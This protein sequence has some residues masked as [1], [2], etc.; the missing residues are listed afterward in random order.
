MGDQRKIIG[1]VWIRTTH[2]YSL[3]IDRQPGSEEYIHVGKVLMQQV[4]DMPEYKD[5]SIT[6]Q[7]EKVNKLQ[8]ILMLAVGFKPPQGRRASPQIRMSCT[9]A[10]RRGVM[11]LVKPQPAPKEEEKREM[12]AA[13]RADIPNLI[14][15]DKE[16]FA[17]EVGTEF[18]KGM[19]LSGVTIYLVNGEFAG[20]VYLR[21]R[22][23]QSIGTSPKHQRQGIA[24]KLMIHALAK[25]GGPSRGPIT[26]HVNKE[27]QGALGWYTSIGFTIGKNAS[28]TRGGGEFKDGQPREQWK[29]TLNRLKKYKGEVRVC[30]AE[31]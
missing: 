9:P 11:P 4:Y 6:T 20:C 19:D 21:G 3:N 18:R 30:M 13:T 23:I 14:T 29:M 22:H 1:A 5:E 27:N 17:E 25:L 24:K 12:R 26:L 8:L 10:D 7:V 15:L 31:M 28:S 2:V 16:I